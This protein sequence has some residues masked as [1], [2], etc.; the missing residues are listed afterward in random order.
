MTL[1]EQDFQFF[2]NF[3]KNSSG[4]HLTSDKQYLLESRLRDVLKIHNLDSM[5]LLAQN[6]RLNHHGQMANDVIEAMTINETFF[7]RDQVPFE[8]FERNIIPILSQWKEPRPFRIWSAACSSGQEPAS[9]AMLMDDH[10]SK[11]PNLN[12]EIL[13]T[14]INTRVLAKARQGIYT[15]LEVHRGLPEKYFKK[16]FK[17]AGP[18]WQLD[19]V[20][21]KRIKY[22]QLNLR[23]NYNIP[24][25][26]DFIMLR[27][28]LIYFDPIMKKQILNK[29]H[30]KLNPNGFLLLGAAEAIYDSDAQV[31]R[32]KDIK[33]LY[34]RATTR[35]II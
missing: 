24:G 6:L 14:D 21:T 8:T 7:F 28:I 1:S 34:T 12:Y 2:T 11:Y 32:S 33:G 26:F 17:A 9:I 13:A 16:Y 29:V 22:H 27:N 18:K 19:D 23:E 4:Y 35:K 20:I 25:Q 15:D 10:K 3:L 5:G 31:E 30:E